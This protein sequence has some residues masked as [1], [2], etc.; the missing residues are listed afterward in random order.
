MTLMSLLQRFLGPQEPCKTNLIGILN[1]QVVT[2]V[3]LCA[4]IGVGL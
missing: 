2:L 3:W 4:I 1:L